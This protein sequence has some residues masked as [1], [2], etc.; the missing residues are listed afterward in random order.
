MDQGHHGCT[1]QHR[2]LIRNRRLPADARSSVG[3]DEAQRAGA[4]PRMRQYEHVQRRIELKPSLSVAS[5]R[6]A[7]QWHCP[8]RTLASSTMLPV[9]PVQ[10]TSSPVFAEFVA[11]MS[12]CDMR[13]Q[14]PRD[15]GACHRARVRATR[16]LA[17]ATGRPGRLPKNSGGH[18]GTPGARTS[19]GREPIVIAAPCGSRRDR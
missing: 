4:T 7:P 15:R 14:R 11:R 1:Y 8:D 18:V 13:E 2:G 10:M 16:W 17:R 9:S 3:W 5:K 6:T 19:F 12:A